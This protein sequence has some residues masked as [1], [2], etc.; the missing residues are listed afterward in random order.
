[1]VTCTSRILSCSTIGRRC[2]L[3]AQG[4]CAPSR[5]NNHPRTHCAA[6]PPPASYKSELLMEPW[7]LVCD[8]RS[9]CISSGKAARHTMGCAVISSGD[10]GAA[11]DYSCRTQGAV[12]SPGRTTPPHIYP[13]ASWY[14]S[15]TGSVGT[16]S[17]RRVGRAARFYCIHWKS[18]RAL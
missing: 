11:L 10:Y 12:V 3:Y 9:F 16:N 1:M 2:C 4:W 7:G 18:A 15:T 6:P 14:P 8:T 5:Q 13:D 17:N